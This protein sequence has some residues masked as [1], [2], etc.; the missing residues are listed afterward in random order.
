MEKKIRDGIKEFESLKIDIEGI[1]HKIDGLINYD[2]YQ[3][4]FQQII[5]EV[6]QNSKQL[7]RKMYS[8]NMTLDYETYIYSPSIRKLQELKKEMERELLP[9][10]ELYLLNKK[11]KESLLDV[12]EDNIN[13]LIRDGKLLLQKINSLNTHN[14][15]DF[16]QLIEESYQ[17]IYLSLLHEE[18]LDRDDLIC[19]INYLSIQEI[20][21]K[22]GKFLRK[23]LDQVKESVLIEEE[24]E[25][26]PLE[27]LGYDYLNS[28]ILRIVAKKVLKEEEKSY[29]LRKEEAISN[30]RNQFND[31]I[32]EKDSKESLINQKKTNIKKLR[33]QKAFSS[34]K[35]L[36]YVL[37]P[38]VS[39]SLGNM[40]GHVLS[41]RITEYKTTTKTI[42]L[43]TEEIVGDIEEIYDE[44]Q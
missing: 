21:E 43:K 23:D 1:F 33:I 29:R 20:K 16:N 14:R 9:Y 6:N 24:L 30:L 22:L 25:N 5:E 8:P 38:A 26:L 13:D 31:F 15:N 40:I 36:S 27:G 7:F 44:E 34:S 39:F 17:I 41:N 28:K 10:Y 32:R 11:M 2:N 37:I 4:E 3:N 18:T 19:Y 35:A 12:K 42:D